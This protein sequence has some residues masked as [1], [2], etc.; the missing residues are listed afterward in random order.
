MKYIFI[1]YNPFS[2]LLTNVI[3]APE[4]ISK[5]KAPKKKVTNSKA[6]VAQDELETCANPDCR[7]NDLKGPR[8][9]NGHIRKTPACQAFYNKLS[10]GMLAGTLR[11]PLGSTV[12][13]SHSRGPLSCLPVGGSMTGVQEE[14]MGHGSESAEL[15]LGNNDEEVDFDN[16]DLDDQS[17]IQSAADSTAPLPKEHLFGDP[18]ISLYTEHP[19]VTTVSTRY[20]IDLMELLDTMNCPHYA[21]E[22]IMQ[23]A[24]EAY[25]AGYDFSPTTRTFQGQVKKIEKSFKM[26][27]M[28]PVPRRFTLPGDELP[29]VTPT[30]DFLAMLFS[31]FNDKELNQLDNLCVNK[32]NP[33]GRYVPEDGLLGEMNSGEVYN[34]AYDN[35]INDPDTDFLLPVPFFMDSTTVSQNGNLK[36]FPVMMSTSIFNQDTRNKSSAWRPI[37]FITQLDT[38]SS[39]ANRKR[40]KSQDKLQSYKRFNMCVKIALESFVEA[41]QTDALEGVLLRLGPYVKKVNIKLVLMIVHGDLEEADQLTGRT[42]TYDSRTQQ[43]MSPHCDIRNHNQVLRTRCLQS[44]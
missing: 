7:R 2:A 21:F 8:G 14:T 4:K 6:R 30:F 41:Q 5:V 25:Q 17:T 15:E 31:L 44:Y 18:K 9:L 28:R 32:N 35:R 33:F 22:L 27:K 42:G 13:F 39:S 24:K 37:G 43:R 1:F 36:S 26:E 11:S 34:T 12:T 29:V 10:D 16:L 3:M 19:V 23:W 20:E 40:L 38:N